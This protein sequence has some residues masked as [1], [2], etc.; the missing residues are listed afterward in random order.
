MSSA[1]LCPVGMGPIFIADLLLSSRTWLLM[2][3][4]GIWE[5]EDNQSQLK[6]H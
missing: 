4:S 5:L 6:L 3:L 1:A 2:D